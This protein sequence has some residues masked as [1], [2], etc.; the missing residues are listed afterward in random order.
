MTDS[1]SERERPPLIGSV[2]TQSRAHSGGGSDTTVRDHTA[3]TRRALLTSRAI[4]SFG[5]GMLVVDF[6]LYLHALG[7]SGASIGGL[8]TGGMALQALL[9]MVSGPL[10][11]RFGRR[12]FLLGY[13]VVTLIAAA[14]ALLTSQ[15]LW[16]TLAAVAGG[17]GRGQN[18]AAGPFAPVEQAWLAGL[19]GARQRGQLFSL[20]GALGSFGMAAGALAAALP[21]LWSASQVGAAA[22]RPLFGLVA[23]GSLGCLAALLVAR[24]VALPAR[25][26][27]SAGQI[28]R[29]EENRRLRLV[30]LVNGVNGLAIGL[31]GPL[32]A[33]WFAL[34]YGVGPAAIAP[35][36]ALSFAIT[37]ASALWA[38]RLLG[39]FG[40]IRTV[41]AMRSVALALLAALPFA[42]SFS[43]ATVLYVT[44]S[45]LNR[46]NAG[47]RQALNLSLVS[48]QRRGLAATVSSL[49]LQLPR[50][51]G[52]LAA[53]PLFA[54]GFLGLPLL[55]AAALQGGYLV[56]YYYAFRRFD[57]AR[58]TAGGD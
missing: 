36:L 42:P 8:L 38:G 11:D 4:R 13:E 58:P 54:A 17:F 40:V 32:I 41:I 12:R 47:A 6:S 15:P 28:E 3:T 5:Q 39:R 31:I 51:L 26:G 43:I 29:R 55:A 56:C 50:A 1:K 34:R 48:A 30:V 24:E 7:W 10:S 35:V 23:L 33:Y 37:G 25:T 53:G 2:A 57:P 46:G 20:S 52:P 22:Y 49:S 45:A 9:V 19:T 44:R 18:G 27:A 14:I 21:A 16:L